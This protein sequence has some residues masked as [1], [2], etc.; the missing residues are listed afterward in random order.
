MQVANMT[1]SAIHL[2]HRLRAIG[3]ELN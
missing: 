2:R 3:Y 1:V